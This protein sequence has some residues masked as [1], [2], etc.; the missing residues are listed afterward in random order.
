MSAPVSYLPIRAK[1]LGSVPLLVSHGSTKAEI[2]R[3]LQIST[4]ELR[5]RLEG[6]ADPALQEAWQLGL[7][8][9][10]AKLMRVII[11]IAEDSDND[12]RLAFKAATWILEH[13]YQGYSTKDQATNNQQVAITI[14]MPKQAKDLAEYVAANA[15]DEGGDHE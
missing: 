2:A 6:D 8:E 4:A 12:S 9:Q 1:L 10:E 3:V 5:R 15:I 7:A 14:M 13:R 11:G